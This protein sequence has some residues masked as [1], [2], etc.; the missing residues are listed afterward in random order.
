MN[1]PLAYFRWWQMLLLGLGLTIFPWAGWADVP[2]ELHTAE[3]IRRLSPTE[4]DRRYPVRI[5]GII[6]FFDDRIPAHSF[7]FIQDD[8]AGIYYYVD[9]SPNNPTCKVGQMVEIQGV[10]GAGSFAPVITAQSTRILGEG[11][12]PEPKSVPLEDLVSGREDSQFVEV[13]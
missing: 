9:G 4:A 6:T 11:K 1:L 10:T 7:R 13:R 12:L 3:E 8:T 5:R 2:Q